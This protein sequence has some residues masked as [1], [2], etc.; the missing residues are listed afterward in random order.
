M[1]NVDGPGSLSE[2]RTFCKLK[3][4]EGQSDT[5]GDGMVV[6]VEGNLYITTHLG[7]Q[8]FSPE[9][10][11][12]GLVTFPEQPANVTF[13]GPDHK[14]MYVTARTGLYRVTMPVAGLLPN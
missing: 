4:P 2:M 1:Y 7:V 5:G 3:Q 11:R 13:G 10:K 8:I 12:L 9:G 14:T 6:D